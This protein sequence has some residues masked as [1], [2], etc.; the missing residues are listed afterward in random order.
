MRDNL[1][2][3]PDNKELIQSFEKLK[4]TYNDLFDKERIFSDLSVKINNKDIDIRN[5]LL[6]QK[7]KTRN[8]LRMLFEEIK[9]LKS[10]NRQQLLD[11]K[12]R[13]Y[14]KKILL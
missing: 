4:D 11:D 13:E 14:L 2:D 8:E 9:E 3:T 10:S 5:N 1:L 7:A 12:I 6:I